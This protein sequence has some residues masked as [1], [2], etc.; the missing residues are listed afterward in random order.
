MAYIHKSGVLHCDFNT[1][2]ILL[3]E[4]PNIKIADFQ[5]RHL[6]GNS[7][8]NVKSSMPRQD[9]NYADQKADIFVLGSTIYYFIKGQEP[10]PDL[11][12]LDDD[13]EAEIIARF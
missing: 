11:N 1:N 7:S 13:D 8:E 2:N 9:L 6:Y 5:C 12:S 3:D 4:N 10:F